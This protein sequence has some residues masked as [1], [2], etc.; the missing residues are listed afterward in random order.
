MCIN[1]FFFFLSCSLSKVRSQFSEDINTTSCRLH[2]SRTY[3]TSAYDG[4]GNFFLII[5]SLCLRECNLNVLIQLHKIEHA[6]WS[7]IFESKVIILPGHTMADTGLADSSFCSSN[8]SASDLFSPSLSS[9]ICNSFFP[10]ALPNFGLYLWN[11]ALTN[12][13][14]WRSV[15]LLS[16]WA[17][18]FLSICHIEIKKIKKN[19]KL[20]TKACH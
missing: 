11:R 1:L 12:W 17:V 6:I 16:S 3:K 19:L 20:N 5:W 13:T 10:P 14:G 2:W 18:F 9:D 4:L 15:C 8:S 7:H